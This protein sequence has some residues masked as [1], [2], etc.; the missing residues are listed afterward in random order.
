MPS[1]IE[2]PKLPPRGEEQGRR[3]RGEASAPRERRGSR[4]RLRTGGGERLRGANVRRATA[5][6]G[7]S[8]LAG[9]DARWEQS[10]GVDPRSLRF[11]AQRDEDNGKRARAPEGAPIAARSKALKTTTPG[12]L[13][14][15]NRPGR[16]RG[17]QA[18][19]GVRN[20]G[21]GG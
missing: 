17:D 14:G 13:P 4:S 12:A 5:G 6:L 3:S 2:T 11:A 1:V 7:I 18:V 10:S 20:A 9:A 21:D 8:V 16:C 15:R 19:E